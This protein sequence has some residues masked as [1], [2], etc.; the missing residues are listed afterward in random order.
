LVRTTPQTTSH[1]ELI[2]ASKEK[3][4][5]RGT[6]GE[7]KLTGFSIECVGQK[8]PRRNGAKKNLLAF[9][10]TVLGTLLAATALLATLAALSALTG[11]RGL[12]TGL[13]LSA[14]LSA[15]AALLAALILLLAHRIS[16]CLL[17]LGRRS[18]S[19]P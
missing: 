8:K 17:P 12:L 2:P 9:D 15:L 6:Y 1:K 4:L 13:L 5:R 7:Y 18:P 10:L 16:P 19:M 11:L 3:F 14:T